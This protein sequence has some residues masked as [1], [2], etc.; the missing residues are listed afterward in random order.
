M[1]VYPQLEFNNPSSSDERGLVDRGASFVLP[2]Q[3]AR[4]FGPI[5]TSL[6]FGYDFIEDAVDEWLYGLAVA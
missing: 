3:V 5:E 6:E 4:R 1:S 2:M